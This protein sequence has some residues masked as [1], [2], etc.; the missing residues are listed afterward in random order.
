[1]TELCLHDRGRQIGLDAILD[2]R[3]LEN[4]VYSGSTALCN[5]KA[6]SY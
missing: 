6:L 2:Y 5:L 3:K 1:M 4:G